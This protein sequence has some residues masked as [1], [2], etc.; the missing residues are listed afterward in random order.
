[1]D[2]VQRKFVMANRFVKYCEILYLIRRKMP[3]NLTF[4]SKC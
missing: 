3:Q 2:C 1:M 4:W